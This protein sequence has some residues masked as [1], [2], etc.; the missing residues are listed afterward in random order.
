MLVLR[1]PARAGRSSLGHETGPRRAPSCFCRLGLWP[2]GVP[3]C[4][5]RP[6]C[7]P[8]PRT[9]RLP[10]ALGPR[11]PAASD[12]THSY[13][14][15]LTS[16]W[17]LASGEPPPVSG[18]RGEREV[19]AFLP[20]PFPASAA[21][22][23][24]GPSPWLAPCCSPLSPG[25]WGGCSPPAPIR[26]AAPSRA[27]PPP[28]LPPRRVPV[29]INPAEVGRACGRVSSL[30]ADGAQC[31]P[32]HPDARPTS[33]SVLCPALDRGEVGPSTAQGTQRACLWAVIPPAGTWLTDSESEIPSVV[34]AAPEV[35]L[36][37]AVDSP[38]HKAPQ[39]PSAGVR[40]L[41]LHLRTQV[42]SRAVLQ[43]GRARPCPV[44]AQ[45]A[46]SG[47]CIS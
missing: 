32:P 3:S 42:P 38:P 35:T 34:W 2:A 1:G 28:H 16:W 12:R 47:Q 26:V 27:H 33:Q 13:P 19:S 14:G 30:G 10:P 18:D 29:R 46:P 20:P 15:P 6:L 40:A 39:C 44:Q 37:R 22:G 41:C 23:W 9:T 36:A 4:P 21:W 11:R 5:H 25:S 7:P 17:G 8:A 43:A 24:P 31:P 45:G